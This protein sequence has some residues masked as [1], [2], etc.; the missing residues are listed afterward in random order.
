M[1]SISDA[2]HVGVFIFVQ[3]WV[4]GCGWDR[5]DV[6][7]APGT[8]GDLTNY[9]VCAYSTYKNRRFNAAQ[10]ISP[11]P[12]LRCIGPRHEGSERVTK[13]TLTKQ[14][15]RVSPCIGHSVW[16]TTT[17]ILDFISVPKCLYH[18]PR[19]TK[20]FKQNQALFAETASHMLHGL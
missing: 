11:Y 2:S 3:V 15:N 5:A 14:I 16:R 9:K 13:Q 17:P 19:G 8:S 18:I 20:R 7:S 1:L 6:S 4:S 12:D 10:S